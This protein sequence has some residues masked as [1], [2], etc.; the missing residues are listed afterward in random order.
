MVIV[1][2][3]EYQP[4]I[5]PACIDLAENH[6]KKYPKDATMALVAGWGLTKAT[7]YWEPSD[8]LQSVNIP[9]WQLIECKGM[10]PWSFDDVIDDKVT[11]LQFTIST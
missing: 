11:K 8:I 2:Y 5:V 3:F 4:H 1:G 6:T 7:G 9:V 10:A